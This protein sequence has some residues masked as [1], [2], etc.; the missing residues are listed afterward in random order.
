MEK[1]KYQR[2]TYIMISIIFVSVALAI[3]GYFL[4][5]NDLVV[6]FIVFTILS[7]L[8]LI[9]VGA[10]RIETSYKHKIIH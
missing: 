4:H 3:L 2:L 9:I 7:F 5:S 10:E 1:K 6:F 8:V